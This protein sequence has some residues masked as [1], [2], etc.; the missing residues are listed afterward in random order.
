MRLINLLAELVVENCTGCTICMK[1]CPTLAI[2][3][4]KN[5]TGV[6]PNKLPVIHSQHC[7][8]CWACEQ[9]C[10]FEALKMVRNPNPRTIGVRV[11]EVDYAQVEALC[12]RAH[13]NPEQI[14]CFCTVTR[15]EEVAAAILQGAETP[16][17]LS[18]RTGIRTGC[19]VECTQ[20]L[21]RL[22]EAAGLS[23]EPTLKEGWQLYGRTV[24]AWEIPAAVK[25]K[26]NDRGFYFDEDLE[27]MKAVGRT[28][29][30]K[31]APAD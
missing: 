22:L 18:Y 2:E 30:V 7:V 4:V 26:Y 21:L 13:L 6:G 8:G 16:E 17:E 1:V 25:A 5:T 20:P 24:T 9:R 29:E 15:A 19:K 23:L 28:Q 14:L 11:E 31:H 3:M 10:P 27:L 12:Q